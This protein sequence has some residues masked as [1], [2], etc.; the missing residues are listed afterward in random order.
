[1][2]DHAVE[3]VGDRGADRAAGL[4]VGTEHEVVDGELRAAVEQLRQRPRP[5]R[6]LE[7]VP[8]LDRQPREPPASAGEL[9]AHPRELLLVRQQL[10]A[11][12]LPFLASCGSVLRHR[13]LLG[14][15]GVVTY[16]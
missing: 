13:W 4:E 11:F 6:G 14:F 5:L 12:G 2:R 15:V 10:G 7:R 9:V 8:L 1:M 3:A 16:S